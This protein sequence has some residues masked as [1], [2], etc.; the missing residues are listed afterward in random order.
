MLKS[1]G[2]MVYIGSWRAMIDRSSPS[3]DG[4]K[5]TDKGRT[6]WFL[7]RSA[8]WGMAMSWRNR[9]LLLV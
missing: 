3:V 7:W 2:S 9:V 4:I 1:K 8:Y 6:A 5:G